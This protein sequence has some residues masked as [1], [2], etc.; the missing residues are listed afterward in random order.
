MATKQANPTAA[1]QPNK[2]APHLLW[3][4]MGCVMVNFAAN[5]TVNKYGATWSSAVIIGLWLVALIPFA[6]YAIVHERSLLS[7]TWIVAKFKE[8]PI[9][10]PVIILIF[11]WIAFS[12]TSRIVARFEH[13]KQAPTV[14]VSQRPP[15]PSATPPA[16]AP[17]EKLAPD[18]TA[19]AAPDPCP[20]GRTIL[21][22]VE[23]VNNHPDKVKSTG[24]LFDGPNPCVTIIHGKA[25]GN[26]T[27][28]RFDAVPRT[29]P[30]P[31]PA[32]QCSAGSQ[33]NSASGGGVINNPTVINNGAVARHLTPGEID[34][35]GLCLSKVH[36]DVDIV[37]LQSNP[38]SHGFAEDWLKVFRRAEWTIKDDRVS[39]GMFAGGFWA[40]TLISMEGTINSDGVS[41]TFAPDSVGKTISECLAGKNF[42]GSATLVPH[43]EFVPKHVEFWVGPIPVQ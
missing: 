3:W 41:A 22:D 11:L 12:Q 5:A 14:A 26:Q 8:H 34:G 42:P 43:P 31:P 1:P 32:Q 17:Q 19:K 39:E 38:E 29:A 36:G 10:A 6:I 7:R 13:E 24:F 20:H 30:P 21:N 9:S 16:S 35:F 33:C 23:A 2:R 18:T 28:Y 15:A 25:K 4:S 27:G 40:G 37:A